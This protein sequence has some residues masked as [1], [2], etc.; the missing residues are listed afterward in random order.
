MDS[1]NVTVADFITRKI[2]S[3]PISQREIA[4]RLGYPNA[5]ILTMFKQGRTKI[6]IPK[7]PELA[8]ALEM[9]PIELL[10]IVM[11]EYQ[12]ETW[13]VLERLIGESLVSTTELNLLKTVREASGNVDIAPTGDAQKE[14]L[15]SLVQKWVASVPKVIRHH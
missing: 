5:N 15:K 9:D 1:N 8:Q 12:P 6:P 11:S 4:S 2:E 13:R 10:R 3:A 14:E 7:V